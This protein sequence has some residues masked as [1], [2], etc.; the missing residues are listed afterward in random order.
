MLRGELPEIKKNYAPGS[1]FII[2]SEAL[3]IQNFE[4]FF[5]LN[6]SKTF[7]G[8]IIS[9][10]MYNVYLRLLQIYI[11]MNILLIAIVKVSDS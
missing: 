6:V 1:K 5:T 2:E 7:M 10:C 3:P 11:V 8:K 4:W 9:T